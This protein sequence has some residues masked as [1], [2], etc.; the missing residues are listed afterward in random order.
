MSSVVSFSEARVA[1]IRDKLTRRSSSSAGLQMYRAPS[2]LLRLAQAS[3]RTACRRHAA[4]F[5]RSGST[6][7]QVSAN[8]EVFETLS[9]QME[10]WARQLEQRAPPKRTDPVGLPLTG[11]RMC[12]E[13]PDDPVSDPSIQVHRPAKCWGWRSHHPSPLAMWQ[14]IRREAEEASIDEP[15]LASFLHS[16]IMAHSSLERAVSFVLANKLGNQTLMPVQLLSVFC[17]V[18]EQD[19]NIIDSI[20]ADLQAVMDRDPACEAYI[21]ILLFFKGFQAVTAHRIAHHLWETDRRP[22]AL[23]LQSRVSE[24]F[25]VDIH[26]A[27]KIGKGMLLDHATG[28]VIGETA[29]VGDN[30]SMLHH[31]T[32]GGSGTGKGCRHPKIGHGVLLGAGANVLGPVRVGDGARVGA[33]SVVVS[34]IPHHSVAVGIP[35]R[36]IRVDQKREPVDD[37]AQ[38]GFMYDYII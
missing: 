28:V 24:V 13:Q 35:A 4:T 17:E 29:V 36:V 19:P 34:D 25:H 33:G 31:V 2:R 9:P 30:V 16:S 3:S 5:D 11:E 20:R 15:A 22:L 6:G 26:P 18:L 12:G 7:K 10:K 37:M 27:A 32:L 21:Q 38:C 1:A 23:A 8:Q 14:E